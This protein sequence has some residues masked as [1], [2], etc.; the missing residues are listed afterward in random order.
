MP[1]TVPTEANLYRGSG[2]ALFAQLNPLQRILF[3]LAAVWA[4]LT[5][6]LPKEAVGVMVSLQNTAMR[7]F[8]YHHVRNMPMSFVMLKTFLVYKYANASNEFGNKVESYILDDNNNAVAQF[9]NWG[10][11]MVCAMDKPKPITV[12]ENVHSLVGIR[13]ILE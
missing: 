10:T 1:A 2:D 8:A 7:K 6:P 9:V 12:S 5:R 11:V 4:V 13:D 3:R